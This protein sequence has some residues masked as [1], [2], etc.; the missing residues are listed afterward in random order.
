MKAIEE[1]F[2]ANLLRLRGGRTQAIIAELAGLPL[3]TYRNIEVKG[4]I[5]QAPNRGAIA[6]AFGVPESHLFVDLDEF[7]P[8][9]G[10]EISPMAAWEIVGKALAELVPASL[11]APSVKAERR[12]ADRELEQSD[13]IVDLDLRIAR[14]LSA[15]SENPS[16]LDDI[17][18][19]ALVSTS[20]NDGQS[21][22][23]KGTR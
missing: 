1:I 4:A 23:Q 22:A 19:V 9:S 10:S 20:T 16:I 6:R 5:P 3:P 14:L 17:E 11:A 15:I 8:G 18:I 21:L 2:R 12:R 7:M 13:P